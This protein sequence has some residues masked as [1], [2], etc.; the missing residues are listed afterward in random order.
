MDTN[1][2]ENVQ[3]EEVTTKTVANLPET[4]TSVNRFSLSK[5]TKFVSRSA[6]KV[7]SR[8]SSVGSAS[9]N[10]SSNI[11]TDSAS[12]SFSYNNNS[13]PGTPLSATD[14][15]ERSR[16]CKK[17]AA[18]PI[19]NE[20][21]PVEVTYPSIYRSLEQRRQIEEK[22]NRQQAMNTATMRGRAKQPSMGVTSVLLR[23]MRQ[24]A[25]SGAGVGLTTGL[26]TT[27][28]CLIGAPIVFKSE[29][30]PVFDTPD[31]KPTTYDK[32]SRVPFL[33]DDTKTPKKMS[34]PIVKSLSSIV[35]AAY[36]TPCK[37]LASNKVA[38]STSNLNSAN[39]TT[40]CRIS[41]FSTKKINNFNSTGHIEPHQIHYE[42]FSEA[43]F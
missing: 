39:S 19:Y 34:K 32:L 1:D 42:S 6:L 21:E 23:Q 37:S 2:K 24:N 28:V 40:N 4:P 41:I 43:V 31:A 20:L 29:P 13:S 14:D 12:S 5:L 11:S 8:K 15:E 26:F 9:S 33:L 3:I 38:P 17:P 16:V 22:L 25:G 36:T 7:M 27:N 10:D 35:S 18:Q 30:K